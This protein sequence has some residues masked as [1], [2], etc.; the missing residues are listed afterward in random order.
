MATPHGNGGNRFDAGQASGDFTYAD[1]RDGRLKRMAIRSIERVTG[2]RRLK[3]LYDAHVAERDPDFWSSAVRRL[4]LVLDYDAAKLQTQLP[5]TGPVVIVANHPYGVLDG[6]MIGHLVQQR[7]PDFRVVAHGILTRSPEAAAFLFPIDFDATTEA[8]RRNL[9]ARQGALA[10]L[11]AGGAVVVFPGGTV[12]TAPR[13]FGAAVD[14]RWKPFT[15]KL[16][17][18]AKAPVLP[19][20]FVGQNSRLFQLASHVSMTLR[21]SLL[22]HEVANKIGSRQRIEI[23]ELIPY[24]ELAPIRDRQ[25]LVDLLRQRTYALHPSRNLA[26]RVYRLR[27][28]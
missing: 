1:P 25:A 5:A 23:G 21:L 24:A 20:C 14:P 3:R 8:R 10:W 4:G 15:A 17:H 26:Q 27:G 9:E 7:R 18:G 13:P 2:Q 22:F 6:L 11:Q 12:S 16:I 28:T 19:V